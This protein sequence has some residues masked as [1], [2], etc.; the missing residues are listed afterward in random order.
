MNALPAETSSLAT[1]GSETPL[2]VGETP[3]AT[4]SA[5][6]LSVVLVLCVHENGKR[7]HLLLGADS[8]AETL[9][10]ALAVWEKR[11]SAS[12]RPRTIDAVKV[13]HHGSPHSHCSQLCLI[14]GNGK[15]GK[16]AVVSAGTRR[17]LPE[18]GVLADYLRNQWTVLITTSR[19]VRK[20]KN[21]FSLLLSRKAPSSFVAGTHDIQLSWTANEGLRWNP[22]QAQVTEADL[23]SYHTHA[24][25]QK[26][27]G[28]PSP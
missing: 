16:V 1:T 2:A 28:K 6:P 12:N 3:E 22:P 15:G 24:S 5:N 10:T 25:Q 14:G 7:L 23:V 18:R 27:A 19:R 9:A 21:H 17:L 20:S 8:D 13:P 26:E 11:A 4:L